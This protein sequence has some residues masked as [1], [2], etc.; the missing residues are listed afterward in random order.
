[1]KEYSTRQRTELLGL[2]ARRPA[3]DFTADELVAE[4]AGSGINRSTVYRNLGHLARD[5]VITQKISDDG[6]RKV[7]RF[8]AAHG[9]AG[10]LHLLCVKCGSIVHMDGELTEVIARLTDSGCGF[11]LKTET[12]VIEGLCK[13]CR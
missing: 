5:G 3:H 13:N 7:Y 1:M 2:L 9:C 11:S 8:N 6:R 4:L 10:H 12:T